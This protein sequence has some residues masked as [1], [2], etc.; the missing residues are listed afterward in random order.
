MVYRSLANEK[1]RQGEAGAFTGGNAR[2]S[3]AAIY[4]PPARSPGGRNQSSHIAA[5]ITVTVVSG[6]AD[7]DARSPPAVMPARMPAG[8]PTAPRGGRGR[9]QRRSTQRYRGDC[10]K[11]EFAE[12]GYL[13]RFGATMRYR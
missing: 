4:Q 3:V 8:V 7:I 11:R 13:L 9:C 2:V 10:S 6:A 1:P 5:A 12:H